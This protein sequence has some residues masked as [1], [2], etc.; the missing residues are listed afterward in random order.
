LVIYLQ[1]VEGTGVA[2]GLLLLVTM[3]PSVFAPLTGV[4]V[5]RI[6]R[7]SVLIGTEYAQAVLGAVIVV[8]LPGLVPLLGLVFAKSV[9]ATLTDIAGRS[10]IP[11]LVDD[12]FLVR[13]NAWFGA[14]RQAAD[15]LGPVLGGL[16]VAAAT[17][18]AAIFVD[19]A[20]FVFG[21]VL[22]FRLPRLRAQI[23]E[24]NSV[25]ADARAGLRY[26]ARDRVVR[27]A[28]IA[29]FVMG[30]GAANDV[31]LPFLAREVGGGDI[32]VGV[33]YASV[34]A[35]L[36]AGFALLTRLHLAVAP[37]VGF[38]AGALVHGAGDLLT[39]LAGTIA[40]VVAFQFVRGIGAAAIDVNLQTLLQ[41]SV[42]GDMLGR[43]FANVYGSVG[44]AAAISTGV[45]G[46]VVDATSPGTV[47]VLSGLFGI[48]GA[49][50][51]LALTRA[52]R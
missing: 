49:A 47:L 19:V 14:A 15:V 1:R 44:I 18:R 39:G 10:A 41:R 9:A 13:A 24:S 52:G 26:I 17:V 21:I 45:A 3:L 34:A 38:V 27:A 32:S 7:R 33:V 25:L 30:L 22:L 50:A 6:D 16:I 23:T 42:P 51:G 29:F 5:D 36:I 2:V 46:V 12:Q 37:F 8:W 28:T 48:A 11:S 35:G 4:V 20:T 40:L 31:A 43:V